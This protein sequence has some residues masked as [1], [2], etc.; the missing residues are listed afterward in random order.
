MLQI[1][2]LDLFGKLSRRRGAS[3]WFHDL[4]SKSY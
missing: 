1:I 4:Q 3:A 2:V